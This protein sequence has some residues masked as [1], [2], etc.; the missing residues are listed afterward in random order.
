MCIWCLLSS[1][2]HQFSIFEDVGG[3]QP[4]P[5]CYRLGPWEKALTFFS[6]FNPLEMGYPIFLFER[7]GGRSLVLLTLSNVYYFFNQFQT[8]WTRS[9]GKVAAD[10]K[11]QSSLEV[12]YWHGILQLPCT[13]NYLKKHTG[14]SWM[15]C[16]FNPWSPNIDLQILQSIGGRRREVGGGGWLSRPTH[17]CRIIDNFFFYFTTVISLGL[18][19]TTLQNFT[20]LMNQLGFLHLILLYV[21]PTSIKK[22]H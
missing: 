12:L 1:L 2:P 3:W 11:A 14:K 7:G 15:V 4:W 20:F 6:E 5:C 13:H 8:R 22:K 10:I 9:F 17:F 21:W 18:K 19:N 16:V